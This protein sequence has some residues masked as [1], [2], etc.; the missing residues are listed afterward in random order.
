ME[1]LFLLMFVLFI[2]VS[3]FIKVYSI[4]KTLRK[5]LIKSRIPYGDYCYTLLEYKEGKLKTKVC[6]YWEYREDKNEHGYGYCH[7]LDEGDY[8][9]LWD[10]VKICG[11]NNYE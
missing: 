1:Y 7:Y 6:P 11:E 9:L 10:S 4:C 8:I 2:G 3:F 5:E